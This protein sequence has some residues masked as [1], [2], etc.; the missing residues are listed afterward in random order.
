MDGI[1][2]SCRACLSASHEIYVEPVRRGRGVFISKAL[3]ERND[4]LRPKKQLHASLRAMRRPG[5]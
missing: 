1:R 2:G 4:P 3:V 5:K